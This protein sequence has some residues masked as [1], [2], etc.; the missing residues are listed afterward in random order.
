MKLTFAMPTRERP[1]RLFWKF[2]FFISLV[3][4]GS[5]LVVGAWIF[6]EHRREAA[7][8]DNSAIAAAAPEA[9]RSAG[10]R[11][12]PPEPFVGGILAS[13]G[14][15][16][17]VAWLLSKPIR[18]LR[19]ALADAASGNLDIRVSDRMGSGDDELKDLGREFDHMINRLHGLITA[20]RQ[21]LHDVSHELRSPLARIQAAIGLGHQQPDQAQALMDRIQRESVR[22]DKLI[23]ELMALSRLQADVDSQMNEEIELCDLLA[24]V[25]EDARFEASAK[26]RHIHAESAMPGVVRGNAALLR[27]AIENVIRNAIKFSNSGGTVEVRATQGAADQVAVISV[28]DSGTGVPE[29]DLTRIFDPFF[30]SSTHARKEGSGLGLAIAK[31]V[32]DS[33][34]GTIRASNVPGGG[35]LVSI[36]LPLLAG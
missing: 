15:A 16:A 34:R 10:P 20:Q 9:A 28:R 3:Q 17:L 21:L 27:R 33:H 25:V 11:A 23:V 31:R 18:N 22:I 2:F 14:S 13:L 19:S 1:S 24:D 8:R 12:L 26:G 6:V 30:R 36:E 32:I 5:I 4:L 29:S 35:L 7:M